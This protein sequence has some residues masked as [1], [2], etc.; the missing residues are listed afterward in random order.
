MPTLLYQ[1]APDTSN[2]GGEQRFRTRNPTGGAVGPAL[3]V[4]VGDSMNSPIPEGLVSCPV[5]TWNVGVVELYV[6]CYERSLWIFHRGRCYLPRCF[7]QLRSG[8]ARGPLASRPTLTR[9]SARILCF[10]VRSTPMTMTLH[11]KSSL[12]S[13]DRIPSGLRRACENFPE[14]TRLSPSTG[15]PDRNWTWRFTHLRR[16]P[17]RMADSRSNQATELEREPSKE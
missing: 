13:Q 7:S 2:A 8:R 4:A 9:K 17:H 16:R 1:N 10:G 14:M 12:M 5:S 6:E 15:T 11:S 3:P